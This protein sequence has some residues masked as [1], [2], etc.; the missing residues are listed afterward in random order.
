MRRQQ[1]AWNITDRRVDCDEGSFNCIAHLAVGPDRY[2]VCP[3]AHASMRWMFSRAS[4]MARMT[5]PAGSERIDELILRHGSQAPARRQSVPARDHIHATPENFRQCILDSADIEST[6]QWLTTRRPLVKVDHDVY[7][8]VWR[9]S[10]P[11]N[12]AEQISVRHP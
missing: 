8:A 4:T 10:V 12:R 2:K 7:V 6:E 11:C 1:L 5:L 9:C 3:L